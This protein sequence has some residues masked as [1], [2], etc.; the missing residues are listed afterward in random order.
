MAAGAGGITHKGFIF[1][2]AEAFAS[3]HFR[4]SSERKPLPLY[5]S[6]LSLSLSSSPRDC[7]CERQQPHGRVD[8]RRGV[9]CQWLPPLPPTP[10]RQQAQGRAPADVSLHGQAAGNADSVLLVG[11]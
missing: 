11:E 10:A 1:L 4:P 6:P 8:V 9:C 2:C 7:S 3:I 5:L